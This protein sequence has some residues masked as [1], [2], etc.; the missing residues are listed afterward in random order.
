MQFAPFDLIPRDDV[1]TMIEVQLQGVME[2]NVNALVAASCIFKRGGENLV[3]STVAL[4]VSY[5]C[6]TGM[7]GPPDVQPLS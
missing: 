2:S 5:F 3:Y 6:P 4:L 7:P 1:L